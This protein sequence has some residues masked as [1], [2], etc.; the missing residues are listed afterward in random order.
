MGKRILYV[1]DHADVLE[2]MSRLLQMTGF[3]VV[4]AISAAEALKAAQ[5]EQFDLLICDLNLP[6][7]S[8]DDVATKICGKQQIPAIAISGTSIDPNDRAN[9]PFKGHLLKPVS[10]DALLEMISNLLA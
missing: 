7:G 3:S 9:S 5:T 2:A 10:F 6:D 1:E 4:S 8:G